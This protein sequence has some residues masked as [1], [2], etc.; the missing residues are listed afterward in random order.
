M[1]HTSPGKMQAPSFL[2]C[3]RT[4]PVMRCRKQKKVQLSRKTKMKLALSPHVETTNKDIFQCC[5]EKQVQEELLGEAAWV[6]VCIRS[7]NFIQERA[8]ASHNESY[9]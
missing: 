2:G 6:R 5:E 9:I 4:D 8:P 3:E 7:Q 1:E